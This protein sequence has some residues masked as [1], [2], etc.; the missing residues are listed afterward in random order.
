[1]LVDFG[2]GTGLQCQRTGKENSVIGIIIFLLFGLIV[3]FVA[4]ALMPGPQKMGVIGTMLIGVAGSVVGGFF[5][6][7][8]AGRALL[9][10]STAG[11]FG[12]LIGALLILLV[13]SPTF[14]RRRLV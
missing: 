1:L 3:G 7:L 4:R 8:L 2:S 5:G 10:L 14:R 9:Q 12:S 11:F 13:L 6:N